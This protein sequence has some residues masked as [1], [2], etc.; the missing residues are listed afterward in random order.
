MIEVI[1]LDHDEVEQRVLDFWDE[2][3]HIIF[4]ENHQ[5]KYGGRKQV[6]LILNYICSNGGIKLYF[7][8]H[9]HDPNLIQINPYCPIEKEVYRLGYVLYLFRRIYRHYDKFKGEIE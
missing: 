2:L 7:H 5:L 9:K 4:S 6:I 1:C 3:H 8:L